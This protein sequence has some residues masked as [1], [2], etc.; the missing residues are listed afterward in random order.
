LSI[1]KGNGHQNA[2]YDVL[3]EWDIGIQKK[4]FV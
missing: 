2:V 1:V 3:H 4:L